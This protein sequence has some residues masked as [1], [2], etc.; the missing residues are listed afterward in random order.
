VKE[1]CNTQESHKCFCCQLVEICNNECS[2]FNRG[3]HN[4]SKNQ[5]SLKLEKLAREKKSQWQ[6]IL[7]EGG[8]TPFLLFGVI[9]EEF[10]TCKA[11]WE[12]HNSHS[13]NQIKK[14][15]SRETYEGTNFFSSRGEETTL[16]S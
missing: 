9:L 11:M 14:I 3:S 5:I 8:V 6:A 7:L 4:S 10:L 2:I 1:Q 15:L 12:L 13:T 16:N